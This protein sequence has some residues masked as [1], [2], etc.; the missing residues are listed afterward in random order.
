M[1]L[2]SH[3]AVVPLVRFSQLY[4]VLNDQIF[5]ADRCH[6]TGE[7]ELAAGYL[8]FSQAGDL[9]LYDQGYPAIWLFAFHDVE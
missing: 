7:H 3:A 1:T 5:Q 9:L 2:A 6:A 4:G 8:L